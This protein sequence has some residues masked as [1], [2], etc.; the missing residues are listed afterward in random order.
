M[1]RHIIWTLDE[2]AAALKKRQMNE[3]DVNVAV[4]GARGNGKSTFAWKL[5]KKMGNFNPKK[6]V[7]FTREDVTDA[8]MNRKFSCI[9]ADEMINSAHN[10]DFFSGDQKTFIKIM[11]MYRDNYNILVG[12]APFFYDL[13][14]QVRKLI[15]IRATIVQRGVAILQIAKNSLYTN[16]PWET[17][18]NKKIEESWINKIENGEPAKPKYE[19]LTTYMGHLFYSKLNPPAEE[20]YK[21]LKAEKRSQLRL[22][23]NEKPRQ[24]WEEANEYIETGKIKKFK[25]LRFFLMGK[26]ILYSKG[27]NKLMAYRKDMGFTKTLTQ[28]FG[29][30]KEEDAIDENTAMNSMEQLIEGKMS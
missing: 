1:N 24:Y 30:E 7:M 26:G 12:S 10:R 21:Q 2:L 14:S 29:R 22:D 28:L 20:L 19:R 3:F 17:N 11:N 18:V 4:D 13:D 6:D 9:D 5:L 15:K 8:I 23:T 16:D 27:K 25:E